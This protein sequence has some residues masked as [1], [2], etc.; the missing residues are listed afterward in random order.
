VS[1]G[2]TLARARRD[3]GLSI[4]EV[5]KRT[6]IGHSVIDGIEHDDYAAC[7]P[8]SRARG[9]IAAIARALGV[10][11][12]PLVEAYNAGPRSAG[13]VA[14]AQPTDPLAAMRESQAPLADA[15]PPAWIALPAEHRRR[16]ALADRRPS[17]WVALGAAVV[18][19]AALGGILLLAGTSGQGIRHAVAAGRSRGAGSAAVH[20]AGTHQ[21]PSGQAAGSP[22]P[23]QSASP[24]AS[25]PGSTPAGSTP[26]STP[27]GSGPVQA[28]V[29]ASIAA[30][31]PGGTGDG[32]SPQLAHHALAGRAGA[33]WHSAWYTTAHFGNLQHGTGLLIDMGRPVTITFVRIALGNRFGAD[34]ALRIGNSPTLAR[35]RPVA[36]AHGAGGVVKLTTAPTRGRYVLL[37]FTRLAPDQAGTFQVSVYDIKLG[38]YR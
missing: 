29:P 12:W 5:S 38:G 21:P 36:Y 3:A 18:V 31:G 2:E 13:Q 37:W 32:D 8:D 15:E 23:A 1:I 4:D 11:S 19:L 9:S 10:D 16:T 17:I 24:A 14:G 35:L 33:P 26:G 25:T 22:R 20:H 28:L 27:A 6:R 30:F 7:G 34:L